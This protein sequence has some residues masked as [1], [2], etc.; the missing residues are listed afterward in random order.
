MLRLFTFLSRHRNAILFL[1][2]E[3]IALYLV[4]RT[5]DW[6]RHRVGDTLLEVSGSI[7]EARNQVTGYFDLQETNR[8]LQADYDSLRQSYAARIQE[9]DRLRGLLVVDSLSQAFVDSLLAEPRDSFDFLP[10][11]VVRNSTHKTYN[12]LTLDQGTRAGVQV[13]MG[14]VA[15]D[16]VVGRV[17]KVSERYALVQSAINADFKLAV[18]VINPHDPSAVGNL[19]FYQWNGRDI[20]YGRVSY[21]P[22]TATLEPNDLVV[23]ASASTIFPPGF[24]VGLLAG[25][26]LQASEGFYDVGMRLGVDF[27]ALDHVFVIRAGHKAAHDA[28][29]ADVPQGNE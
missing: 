29:E 23:T 6:Q 1:L 14:V 2:L 15:T 22:E 25:D 28:L 11:R 3:G 17:I 7:S 27:S 24:R 10:A 16:G 19:G 21:I 4:V 5:N 26:N 13:G 20:R 12:Y 18:E 8:R 9:L